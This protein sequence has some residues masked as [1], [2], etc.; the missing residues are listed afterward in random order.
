M[1][2]EISACGQLANILWPVARPNGI[3]AD[4]HP[5][6]APSIDLTRAVKEWKKGKH[7]DTEKLGPGD[8]ESLRRT[9]STPEAQ[10]LSYIQITEE[11]ALW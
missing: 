1:I 2:S 4:G 3:T 9:H 5:C 8:L 10:P 7:L 6:R 11:Q